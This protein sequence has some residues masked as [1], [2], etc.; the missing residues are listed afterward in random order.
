MFSLIAATTKKVA[1]TSAC[2]N[3]LLVGR[4]SPGMVITSST[5]TTTT[6]S[7]SST[8]LFD[9][10]QKCYRSVDAAGSVD[11]S[12]QPKNFF[13]VYVHHVSKIVLEHLQESRADWL[14]ENGLDRGLYIN[15][16]GTFAMHFPPASATGAG[17]SAAA[18]AVAAAQQMKKTGNV[19]H[20]S[21]RIW[22]SYDTVRKQH[23]LSVYHQKL[24]V[25]FLL[26]DHGKCM[27]TTKVHDA[28]KSERRIK[29]AVDQMI[30]SVNQLEESSQNPKPQHPPRP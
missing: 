1:T 14:L 26:K 12:N 7:S 19:L 27:N 15:P 25:R 24:A 18:S 6:S 13:P 3:L 8:P 23:W 4:N 20:H 17:T 9:H 16:N 28:T 5:T 30:L 21:G 11:E 29:A 2:K 22:T 10:Y